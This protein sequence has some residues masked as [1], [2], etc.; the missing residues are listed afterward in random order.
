MSIL[1]CCWMNKT[2]M[3]QCHGRDL[4]VHRTR[5]DRCYHFFRPFRFFLPRDTGAME[6]T[7]GRA[8]EE[9]AGLVGSGSILCG[10]EENQGR[11]KK[12]SRDHMKGQERKKKER[13]GGTKMTDS[14]VGRAP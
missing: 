3:G 12:I 14:A 7:A 9:A 5:A 1:K 8:A 13:G 10:G 11:K 6:P 2:K 4:A